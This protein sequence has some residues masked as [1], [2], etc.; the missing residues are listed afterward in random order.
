MKLVKFLLL[1]AVAFISSAAFAQ[2]DESFQF[3]DKDGNVITDGSTITVTEIGDFMGLPCISTGLRV[4]KNTTENIGVSAS[5]NIS[6][7]DNG[8]LKC[9]FPASC[10]QVITQ[11]TEVETKPSVIIEESSDFL[12]EWIFSDYGTCTTTFKLK[13]YDVEYNNYGLPVNYTYKADGPSVTVNFVYSDPT[14]INSTEISGDKTVTG[15]YTIGGQQ[16]EQLQ[17]GINIVKYSNGKSAKI[18]VK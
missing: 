18:V 11:P 16:I 2:I 5:L 7:I 8:G 10:I 14:G 13:I 15:I 6:R 1:S 9:C 3:I 17:K 4:K 12:T